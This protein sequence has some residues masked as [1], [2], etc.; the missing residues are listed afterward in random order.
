[1]N[2]APKFSEMNTAPV[3]QHRQFP[4]SA[5]VVSGIA[6]FTDSLA[7][8]P[9]GAVLYSLLINQTAESFGLYATAICFVWI[10]VLMLLQFSGMYRFE[11]VIKPIPNIDKIIV[12]FITSFLFLLA[13]AFSFKVSSTL[14]RIWLGSFAVATFSS[15]LLL[16]LILSQVV[17]GLS[18][19]G[20]FSR[21]VILVGTEEHVTRLLDQIG[22]NKPDF[23]TLTCVFVDGS[24]Q[25]SFSGI[26]VVGGVNDIAAYVRS[27]RVDDVI[28]AMPWSDEHRILALVDQ[29]REL[30]VNVY[31]G[32][33]LVG[34]SLD[35]REPPGHFAGSPIFSVVGHPMSGWGV[36][37]K[38]TE[39]YALGTLAL[40]V[41]L[42]IMILIAVAIKI[43]SP[44]PVLFKQKRLG[45]NNKSFEI[46]KF[47]TMLVGCAGEEKTIQATKSDPR[48]TRIGKIP[49]SLQLG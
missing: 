22:G 30:P 4:I 14:S 19:K 2:E 34:L 9:V 10:T 44:G 27:F 36:A 46:F 38:A 37:V 32:S 28:I 21:I 18:R 1:M 35:F 29:L 31:L 33:D 48:V 17:T 43:S 15:T 7:I 49:A 5:S 42:P 25:S 16:R 3:K 26:P 39:D 47:R 20:L 24:R 45:F 41:S 11:S 13:A 8:L 6:V 23:V 40:I 12:T